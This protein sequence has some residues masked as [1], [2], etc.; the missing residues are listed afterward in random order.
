MMV[1]GNWYGW[2]PDTDPADTVGVPPSIIVGYKYQN[3]AAAAEAGGNVNDM[4]DPWYGG[5]YDLD[6]DPNTP[7][8]DPYGEYDDTFKLGKLGNRNGNVNDWADASGGYYFTMPIGP[9]KGV[10]D[11]A[12]SATT[13]LFKSYT[14]KDDG[15]PTIW[16]PVGNTRKPA[17]FVHL[18]MEVVIQAIAVPK[19]ADGNPVWWLEAWY[20]ATGKEIEKLNPNHADNALFLQKFTD[21]D[22]TGMSAGPGVN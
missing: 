6:N 17:S 8:V 20:E 19:D 16:L 12:Q 7:K 2:A 10:G 4:V 21:G 13:D 15:V 22:Y 1:I 11:G 18:V 9:G 14:L 3:A 5:G